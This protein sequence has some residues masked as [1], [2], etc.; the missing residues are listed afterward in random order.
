M[1]LDPPSFPSVRVSHDVLRCSR[2]P[3]GALDLL[4]LGITAHVVCLVG[5]PEAG[6]GETCPRQAAEAPDD[7]AHEYLGGV[8][9]CLLS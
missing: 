4:S 2:R 3:T 8:G 9:A 7:G 5:S 6:A 1:P